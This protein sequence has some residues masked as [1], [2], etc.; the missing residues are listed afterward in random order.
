MT[1]QHEGAPVVF[2]QTRWSK[3]DPAGFVLSMPGAEKW[4][5]L[6]LKA[7]AE[8]GDI[9]GRPVGDPLW[10]EKFSLAF[11][12]SRKM[13]DEEEFEAL[14]QQSP[15]MRA[16]KILK[17]DRWRFWTSE[18]LPG[19]F[20]VRLIIVD[21]TFEE[22]EEGK[23]S[24]FAIGY[25][26]F[27]GDDIYQLDLESERMDFDVQVEMTRD[28]SGKHY[29]RDGVL[30]EKKA[31]GAAIINTLQGEV[32][33]MIP[34][35]PGTRSKEQ[36]AQAMMPAHKAGHFYLPADKVKHVWVDKAISQCA[37]FPYGELDDIV[38]L[39]SMAYNWRKMELIGGDVDEESTNET[40]I[41][42]R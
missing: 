40:S 3:K 4:K 17:R 35:D 15:T 25:F 37:D 24:E 21:P 16:G 14:Y 8:K 18:S 39:W 23:N 29:L 11:Y 2:C 32:G 34:Y 5:I 30:I 13:E 31:N 42:V 10:P 20:D 38:D 1:R 28:F 22:G 36:R 27:L 12:E 9:L 41:L 7:I 6:D 26:G 33:G 19:D